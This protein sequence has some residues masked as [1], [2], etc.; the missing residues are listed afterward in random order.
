MTT[1]Q[2]YK[3]YTKWFDMNVRLIVF[4][5]VLHLGKEWML[6]VGNCSVESVSEV[7]APR[8]AGQGRAGRR[9]GNI[10]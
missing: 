2:N 8:R 10:I 4:V 7:W 6:S 3:Q 1:K 9:G 5:F